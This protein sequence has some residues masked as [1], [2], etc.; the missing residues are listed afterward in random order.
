VNGPDRAVLL[1]LQVETMDVG[2][3]RHFASA[4]EKMQQ[5][6]RV[7]L[8]RALEGRPARWDIEWPVQ[9]E[10]TSIGLG[11]YVAGLVATGKLAPDPTL[12]ATGHLDVTG[13]VR[14]V[15]G[16]APKL[17]AAQTSGMRRVLL[18]EENRQEADA[19]LAQLAS[20][21]PLKLLF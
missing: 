20:P 15:D 19:A 12:A 2:E 5:Q 17:A 13:E 7:A 4:D 1:G 3:I 21:A 10:G 8:D 16:V 9:F 11:I 14:W 6:A 18:P